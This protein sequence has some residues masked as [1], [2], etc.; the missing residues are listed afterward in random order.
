[1]Y[2]MHHNPDAG[3][4]VNCDITGTEYLSSNVSIAPVVA[5]LDISDP[6]KAGR[7]RQRKRHL[8]INIHADL[9]YTVIANRSSSKRERKST[10]LP[11]QGRPYV[12]NHH[13]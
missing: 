9:T 4:F 1:M 8:E 12:Q 10:P 5:R 6:R 13:V 11:Y 3:C 2:E 7:Q